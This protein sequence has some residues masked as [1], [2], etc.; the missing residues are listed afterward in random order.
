MLYIHHLRYIKS[1]YIPSLMKFRENLKVL[2]Q[3]SQLR[4]E[5][6]DKMEKRDERTLWNRANNLH[7]KFDEVSGETEGSETKPWPVLIIH[8]L[9]W[10]YLLQFILRSIFKDLLL[11]GTG[12]LVVQF[13]IIRQ[14]ANVELQ[15]I[16]LAVVVLVAKA[17][18]A[19]I[20][21]Q[22]SRAGRLVPR[23]PAVV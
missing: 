19:F 3:M 9:T 11:L 5:S 18:H 10:F 14:I 12:W 7:S 22:R 20:Q 16:L 23:L 1:I 8:S 2:N 21:H 17:I 15:C 6:L 4:F 13:T